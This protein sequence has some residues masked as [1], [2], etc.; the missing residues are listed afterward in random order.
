MKRVNT[1]IE[2]IILDNGGELEV[3]IGV[4]H[5]DDKF[6]YRLEFDGF[7][8]NEDS[9]WLTKTDLNKIVRLFNAAKKE[10]RNQ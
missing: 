2:T 7:D 9:L 1:L 4:A 5:D 6:K 8:S 3:S 10:A